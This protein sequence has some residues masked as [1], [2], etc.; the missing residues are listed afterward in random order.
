MD[1][2]RRIQH[3]PNSC[4]AH[5]LAGRRGDEDGRIGIARNQ[6]IA[7]LAHA[8][9]CRREYRTRKRDVVRRIRG[10]IIHDRKAVVQKRDL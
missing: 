6:P 8:E 2:R 3:E 5:S 7:L 9:T 1:G 10:C 4:N